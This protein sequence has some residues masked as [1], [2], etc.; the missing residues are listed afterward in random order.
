MFGLIQQKMKLNPPEEVE[1][2]SASFSF[3]KSIFKDEDALIQGGF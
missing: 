3:P 1:H 2:K